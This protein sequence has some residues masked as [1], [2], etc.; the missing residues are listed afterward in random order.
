MSDSENFVVLRGQLAGVVTIYDDQ[1][2]KAVFTLN[3]HGI[4]W[5]VEGLNCRVDTLRTLPAGQ[6]LVVI[7]K[8]F[9]RRGRA[10]LRATQV[11]LAPE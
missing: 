8:L 1:I 10:A 6:A 7:G 11:L 9:P 4:R 2:P 5:Y 3:W